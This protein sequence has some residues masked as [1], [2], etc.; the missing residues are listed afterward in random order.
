MQ[1]E[2]KTLDKS[3]IEI[4]IELTAEEIQPQ[5][6]KAAMKLSEETKI[7]GFRPGKAPYDIVRSKLGDGAILEQAIDNIV[8]DAYYAVLKDKEILTIGQPK[9]DIEKAAVGNEFKFKAVVA[10]LPKVTLGDYKSIKLARKSI[11][12]KNEQVEQVIADIQKMRATETAVE[13]EAKEGDKLEIDF[14]V[15]LD[16][17]PIEHGDQKKYPIVIGEKKFIPGFEDQLVGM[18]KGETKEFDLK[19]PE[20]YFQKKL[21]GKL[22]RFKVTCNEI[23][24][25]KLPEMNDEFAKNISQEQFKTLGEMKESIKKNIEQ[26]E[27]NKQEQRLEIEM[28]DKIVEMSQ[29]EPLPDIL[30]EAEVKKM[31]SELEASIS[32]QGFKYE[33]YLKSIRKTPEEL[34]TEMKPQAEK[35]VKT[36]IV[37]REIFQS[38]KMTVTDDEVEKEISQM[39]KAYPNNPE[40]KKQLQAETYREYLKHMLGNRKVI[41]FLKKTIISD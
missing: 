39:L 33:D 34:A 20:E 16:K 35:R 41:E 3:Q 13:R 12:V 8:L 36:A 7:E 23:F 27:K 26:E 14:K 4:K 25:V 28:L 1:S 29:F 5:L 32:Q 17:V 6:E 21:A 2:V 38:E 37:C 11:E 10:V 24:E 18:K 9:I 15:Y 30:L 19:F 22:C 31:V 40:V